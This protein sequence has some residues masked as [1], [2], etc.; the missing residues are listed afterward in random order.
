MRLCFCGIRAVEHRKCAAGLAGARPGL[1][2]QILLNHTS[3]QNA[4]KVHKK[5]FDFLLSIEVQQ[6]F[7][8]SFTLLRH[9]EM[10]A[11]ML[12]TAVFELV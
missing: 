12:K 6:T 3:I 8:F 4:Y 5:T 2:D 9:Y 10:D 7:S 1:Q 11:S